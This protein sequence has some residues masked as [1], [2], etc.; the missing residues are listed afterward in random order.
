MRAFIISRWYLTFGL[1]ATLGVVT[2]LLPSAA[3]VWLGG[4]SFCKAAVLVWLLAYGWSCILPFALPK[5]ER[6]A[7]KLRCLGCEDAEADY[8]KGFLP[9]PHGLISDMLSRLSL[10]H[11]SRVSFHKVLVARAKIFLR[12]E[13]C[14]AQWPRCQNPKLVCVQCS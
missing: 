4:T 13:Q 9:Q 6:F 12:D 8:G 7:C 3:C 11:F 14:E 5:C 1:T 10:C 2:S